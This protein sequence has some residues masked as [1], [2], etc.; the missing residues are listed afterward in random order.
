MQPSAATESRR[1]PIFTVGRGEK[2][3]PLHLMVDVSIIELR[4]RRGQLPA[5]GG[6]GLPFD[7]ADYLVGRGKFSIPGF[8]DRTFFVPPLVADGRLVASANNNVL[9]FEGRMPYGEVRLL[10]AA[11]SCQRICRLG[12]L[13]CIVFSSGRI[14][15]VDLAR[16]SAG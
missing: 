1:Y 14:W 8:E 4:A 10:P 12:S 9:L 5:G 6:R 7:V 15:T 2:M 3:G 16:N 11:T 13:L